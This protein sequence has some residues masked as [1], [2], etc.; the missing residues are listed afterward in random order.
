[1][2]IICS[3]F[4]VFFFVIK[5]IPIYF[6]EVWEKNEVLLTKDHG[7]FLNT[8]IY[9]FVIGKCMFRTLMNID[10]IFYLLYGFFA[11]IATF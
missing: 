3:N 7:F 8:L 4:V 2:M 11:V 6:R 5:K 1:M 9:L 10:V